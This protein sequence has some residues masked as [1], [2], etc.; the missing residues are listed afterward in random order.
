[1]S[2][3]NIIRGES[4]LGNNTG[5]R[6]GADQRGSA[7]DQSSPS[8][9][10]GVDKI[11]DGRDTQKELLQ[12]KSEEQFEIDYDILKRDIEKIRSDVAKMAVNF[13]ESKQSIVKHFAEDLIKEGQSLFESAK[14]SSETL[15]KSASETSKKAATKMEGQIQ[16]RPFMSIVISFLAGMILAKLMDRK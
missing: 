1:M 12:E 7:I 9:S 8:H 10:L 6:P 11:L 2:E 15:V 4:K 14:S 13:A 5:Y 16:E 3:P